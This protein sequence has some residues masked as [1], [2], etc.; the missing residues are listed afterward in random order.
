MSKKQA[1]KQVKNI[2]RCLKHLSAI[3]GHQCTTTSATTKCVL[4]GNAG[5]ANGIGRADVISILHPYLDVN[6]Y[7][8][9]FPPGKQFSI[10]FT[11]DLCD[12]LADKVNTSQI[13]ENVVYCAFINE[14]ISFEISQEIKLPG[15]KLFQDIISEEFEKDLLKL[16]L[17][18]SENRSMSQDELKNRVT[19]HYG[20]KFDYKTNM[21]DLNAPLDHHPIPCSVLKVLEIIEPNISISP[22]QLTVNIY[23]PGQGIPKHVD[24]HSI[25]TS[26]ILSVSLGSDVVMHFKNPT[27]GQVLPV[28]IPSRSLTVMSGE[29]R[30]L[31]HHGITPR[32]S[33]ALQDLTERQLRISLTLRECTAEPCK[34][35][36]ISQC[37]SQNYGKPA[38]DVVDGGARL[39][40]QYVSS[41]YENIAAHFS[42]TRH[43]P[44]PG[45]VN[46]LNTLPPRALVVDVG[47]G[48]GKYLGVREDVRVI[49]NDNSYNLCSICRD[50][51]H[52]VFACNA[53][54]IPLRPGCFDS[55]ICIAML[56]HIATPSRR[57]AVL[58]NLADLLT[59]GGLGLVTVW[60]QEQQ[61]DMDLPEPCRPCPTDGTEQGVGRRHFDSQDVFVDWKLKDS[62][63]KGGL[64]SSESKMYYRYYH[65]FREGELQELFSE[66][67]SIQLL[68]ITYQKANW[69]AVFRKL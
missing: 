28:L 15:L 63:S 6:S 44:W 57:V 21:V 32:K 42:S 33:D 64:E 22:N 40:N 1:K 4:L 27:T 13:R 29:S 50:R 45:V 69:C 35:D 59:P 5:H 20:Y 12:C 31:W 10:L 8:L 48:N 37:D 26:E 11:D 55:V 30:Y 46:F 53:L 66:V 51:D 58:Q 68:D 2:Q 38:Y 62:E 65:V 52:E 36:Y 67:T 43:S 19:L 25:F 39:E 9:Y 3:V 14:Q 18:H 34:C 16:F 61:L 56:H 54:A 24:T 60:A 7:K 17:E 47:C 41:V 23:Q 49:G